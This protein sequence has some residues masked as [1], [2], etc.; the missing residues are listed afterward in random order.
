MLKIL[1]NTL[2][3]GICLMPFG[4]IAQN[5]NDGAELPKRVV[6]VYALR[7][8]YE[9]NLMLGYEQRLS[10][11]TSVK[12]NGSV[13]YN[14]DIDD[15]KSINNFLGYFIEGQYRYYP[16]SDKNKGRFFYVGPYVLYKT[17][18]FQY[19]ESQ[20]VPPYGTRV[21]DGRA[22]AFGIGPLVGLQSIRKSLSI[23]IY[24]G[25][26][27]MVSNG[28]YLMLKNEFILNQYRKAIVS[29]LGISVGVIIN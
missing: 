25:G 21:K 29:H 26:G 19:N 13:S 2:L 23:D 8:L 7:M 9:N 4:L 16:S 12:I 24:Y 3:L 10:P 5:K 15:V 18:G 6:S 14:A 1:L 28:D 17:V 27:I 20:T 11:K 22:S